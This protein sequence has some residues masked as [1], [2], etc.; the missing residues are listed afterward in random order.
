MRA[1]HVPYSALARAIADLL[2]GTN[3]FQFI[4]PLPVLDLIAAGKLHALAVTGPSRM[5]AL[6]DVPTVIEEGFPG[7]V[8]QDWFGLLVKSGTPG[9]V[10]LRLNEAINR[11]LKKPEVHEAIAKLGAEP[12]GGSP[13]EFAEFF[14]AQLE[15]WRKVVK[16]SGMKM[17]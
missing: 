5:P 16:K 13:E 7:L 1:L 12:A 9:D 4:T 8:I 15:H 17:N 2:N 10:V 11:A 6:K 3:Q 14:G